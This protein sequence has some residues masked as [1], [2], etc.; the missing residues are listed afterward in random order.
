MIRSI[1]IFLVT[2]FFL[3]ASSQDF[4]LINEQLSLSDSLEYREHI[5]IYKSYGITNYTS[6]FEMYSK[7]GSWTATFYEYFTGDNPQSFQTVLKSKNDPDYVFQNFLRSYAM[8]LPSM[9]AIR[10]KMNNRQ[11]IRVV[12]DTFRGIPQTKYWS[13][14]KT[15][16]FVDGDY[17]VIE[18]R[19]GNVINRT[20][21]SNPV[22]YLK[23]YPNIDELTYFCEII[24]IAKNEFGIWIDE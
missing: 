4:S 8:D 16:Q 12:K 19:Y 20:E 14:S 10:W 7:D 21:F 22:N 23:A 9:E 1:I 17:F 24:D 11:P 6:V 15:L 5:R 18:V 2:G 13:E 3:P